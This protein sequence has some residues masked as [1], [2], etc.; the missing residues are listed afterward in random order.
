MTND[1]LRD[2]I[3]ADLERLLGRKLHLTDEELRELS[4]EAPAFSHYLR[5]AKFPPDILEGGRALIRQMV[6]RN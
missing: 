1:Q 6:L 3:L 4:E 5:T 2:S